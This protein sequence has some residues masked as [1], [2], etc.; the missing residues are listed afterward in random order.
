MFGGPGTCTVEPMTLPEITDA[1]YERETASDLPVL[2]DFSAPWCPPCRAL[3]PHLAAVAE[4]YGGR[5]VV[6]KV[7]ADQNPEVVERFSVRSLPTLILIRQ[8]RVVG[9]IVGAV[10]RTRIEALVEPHLG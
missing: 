8:R 3:E 10:P 2:L 5:L 7:D 1:T 9:Q 6:A 4:Q